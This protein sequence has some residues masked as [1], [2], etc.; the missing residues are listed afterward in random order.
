[1]SRSDKFVSFQVIKKIPLAS[2]AGHISTTVNIEPQKSRRKHLVM[3]T[4]L[5][6]EVFCGIVRFLPQE[7][8]LL[9]ELMSAADIFG[10]AEGGRLL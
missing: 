4:E 6:F 2:V 10:F 8:V 1:M 7:N 3:S 9:G 5:C